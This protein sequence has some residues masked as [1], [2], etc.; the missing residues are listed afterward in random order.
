MSFATPMLLGV[1]AEQMKLLPDGAQFPLFSLMIVSS[2]LCW[3]N[4]RSLKCGLPVV[5]VLFICIAIS[6][7]E[8]FRGL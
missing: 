4:N 7:L 6:T 8:S 5:A 2:G 3:R 1:K